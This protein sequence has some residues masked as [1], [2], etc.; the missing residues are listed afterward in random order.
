MSP[1]SEPDACEEKT[2]ELSPNAA[3]FQPAI[4][5]AIYNNGVPSM[6]LVSEAD[7][8]DLLHGI[9][10]PFECFPPVATDAAELEAV[11]AFV[12]A[13]ATLALMEEREEKARNGFAYFK[14]RWEARRAAGLTGRPRPA[15]HLVEPVPHLSKSA[16]PHDDV[17]SLVRSYVQQRAVQYDAPHNKQPRFAKPVSNAHGKHPI[18]QP[19]KQN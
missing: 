14:K 16:S 17:R 19:R 3:P 4:D 13:M 7:I 9:E 10:D 8:Y 6:M 1:F 11:D 18:Q 12:E 2:M 15:K 5:I